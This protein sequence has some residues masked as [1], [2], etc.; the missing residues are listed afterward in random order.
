MINRWSRVLPNPMSDSQPLALNIATLQARICK[1]RP[2]ARLSILL[3][4][5][6]ILKALFL[7]MLGS[8]PN[9]ILQ[10]GIVLY[11]HG[12]SCELA[13]PSHQWMQTISLNR[14]GMPNLL[15]DIF[16]SETGYLEFGYRNQRLL[17]ESTDATS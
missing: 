11:F 10:N 9:F 8:L 12:Q 7:S 4:F 5:R 15:F 3:L 17:F 6:M 1:T 13:C 16:F 14:L 2:L